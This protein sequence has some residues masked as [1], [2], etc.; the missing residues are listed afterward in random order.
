ML[1]IR[2]MVNLLMDRKS[3]FRSVHDLAEIKVY[4]SFLLLL[5]ASIRKIFV[6][7][8]ETMKRIAVVLS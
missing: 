1:L 5:F 8:I 4:K 7:V 6:S 3:I 2:F